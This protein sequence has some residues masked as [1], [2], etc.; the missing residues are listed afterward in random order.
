MPAIHPIFRIGEPGAGNCH[1]ERFAQ[2]ADAP[3]AYQSMIRVAKAMALTAYDLI[4]EPAL[5]KSARDE[6]AASERK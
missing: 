2:L 1:E 3:R 4:A 6:F 5:M